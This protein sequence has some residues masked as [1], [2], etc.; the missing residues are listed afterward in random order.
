LQ[1][2]L[3][4]VHGTVDENVHPRHTAWLQDALRA[5]GRAATVV[6]LRNQRHTLRRPAARR[7]WLTLALD[8]L[9]DAM[10][11]PGASRAVRRGQA[12][13]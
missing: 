3:L 7:R 11:Q 9:R 1:G 4:L 5:G 8:H 2:R 12:A 10:G 13:S 6:T